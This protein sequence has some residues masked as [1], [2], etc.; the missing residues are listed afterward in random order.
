MSAK[1]RSVAFGEFQSHC[2]SLLDEVEKTGETLIVTRQGKPVAR[3]IPFERPRPLLGSV[4]WEGDIVSPIDEEWDA[5][6]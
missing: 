5:E 2:S 3:V 6:S 4:V 1:T